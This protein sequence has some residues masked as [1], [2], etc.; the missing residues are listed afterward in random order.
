M[1]SDMFMFDEPYYSHLPTTMISPD[2]ISG[3][4]FTD[5][6]PTLSDSSIDSIFHEF[7]DDQTNNSRSRGR[8]R[9]STNYQNTTTT[10]TTQISPD[11]AQS[12][13]QIA[14]TLFTNSPPSHQL[15]TLSL[16]QQQQQQSHL[17]GSLGNVFS[18]ENYSVV[19]D[20]I[21]SED[22]QMGFD[23]P[24]NSYNSYFLNSNNSNTNESSN[25]SMLKFM[26]R[27]YSSNS[28]DGKPSF[29]F[30]PKFNTLLEVQNFA[31]ELE[32]GQMRRVCSTGDLPVGGRVCSSTASPLSG[33][34]NT[35]EESNFKV[36]KYSAEERKERIDRYRAK[37][38]QRNFNKTIK[39][40]CRKTL[41]DNR[42]R[43]RGRF[44]RN[45]ETGEIPKPTCFNRYEDDDDLWV[46][47]LQE[48]DEEGILGRG[49]GR[50]LNNFGATH[51]FQYC[52]Y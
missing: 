15:E 39:Y 7:S 21:K 20:S 2:E 38:T 52:G 26:Q 48:E 43:V 11:D 31:P 22:F 32:N 45:D 25:E 33:E 47:N 49:G 23:Y 37:R 29:W 19:S 36:G 16:Q 9:N 17:V 46:D 3:N 41:A 35:T 5:Q 10:T 50:F 6:I 1:S 12:L 42:P 34:G 51:H 8:G 27:S 44:A 30:Q 40:A 24:P 28:F 13:D 18:S 14:H 4:F